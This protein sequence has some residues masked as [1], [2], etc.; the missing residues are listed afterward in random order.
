MSRITTRIPTYNP[1]EGYNIIAKQ[2]KQYHAHLD[3]FEK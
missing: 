1:Q 2:Y 3:S